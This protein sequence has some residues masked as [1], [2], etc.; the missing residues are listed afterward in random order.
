MGSLHFDS[1]PNL[2]IMKS[3]SERAKFNFLKIENVRVFF[4]GIYWKEEQNR[5][6]SLTTNWIL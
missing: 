5:I 2:A 3:Q 6:L 1:H 4:K